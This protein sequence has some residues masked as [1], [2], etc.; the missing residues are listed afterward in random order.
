[1]SVK[2]FLH[3]FISVYKVTSTRRTIIRGKEVPGEVES[4]DSAASG[5]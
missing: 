1:M 2:F 5:R 4:E 3:T